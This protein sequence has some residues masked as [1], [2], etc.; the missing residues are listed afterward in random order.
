MGRPHLT[1][2][3]RA[4]ED[5]A[6]TF[7]KAEA[8]LRI[9]VRG[10]APVASCDVFDAVTAL[11]GAVP[12]LLDRLSDC[13]SE[14]AAVRVASEEAKAALRAEGAEQERGRVAADLRVGADSYESQWGRDLVSGPLRAAADRYESG[15]HLSEPEAARLLGCGEVWVYQWGGGWSADAGFH[16]IEAPS[17]RLAALRLLIAVL[18]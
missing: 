17:A 12:A 1:E 18:A 10:G 15:A 14:L 8:K 9:E 7:A 13:R 16:A 4:I 2:Q 5:A 11:T 3:E 6:A